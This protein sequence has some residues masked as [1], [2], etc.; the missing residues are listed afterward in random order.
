MSTYV[1]VTASAKADKTTKKCNMT[2][3]AWLHL[4]LQEQ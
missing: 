4:L 2:H 1:D 3:D